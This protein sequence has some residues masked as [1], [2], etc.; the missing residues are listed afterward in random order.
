MPHTD[1]QAEIPWD[2]LKEEIVD[3]Y[4]HKKYTNKQIREVIARRE[5]GLATTKSQLEYQLKKWKICKNMKEAD[6]IFIQTSIN[7]KNSKSSS[8]DHT[9]Y[10]VC[11]SGIRQSPRRI[12]KG[13]RRLKARE[14]AQ[15]VDARELQYYISEG[16]EITNS[17]QISVDKAP[18][19]NARLK[20]DS[21]GL[22]NQA[23]SQTIGMRTA[24]SDDNM[25]DLDVAPGSLW[26][27]RVQEPPPSLEEGS[28]MLLDKMSSL[29]RRREA[30]F[31]FD[32]IRRTLLIMENGFWED[33]EWQPT[34]LQILKSHKIYS[35]LAS[36]MRLGTVESARLGNYLVS[37][38]CYKY[39]DEYD[40]EDLSLLLSCGCAPNLET[41]ETAYRC[42]SSLKLQHLF[43]FW[44]AD[45]RNGLDKQL[46]LALERRWTGILEA[47]IIMNIFT[48]DAM[49]RK[50]LT[51]YSE[52]ALDSVN[53]LTLDPRSPTNFD[54][55]P[56]ATIINH[57]SKFISELALA[58]YNF[59]KIRLALIELLITAINHEH[60]NV[61]RVLYI[62][63]HIDLKDSSY[64][65]WA[66]SAGEVS[67]TEWLLKAGANPNCS[68]SI[69]KARP[70]LPYFESA[71]WEAP[72]SKK[73]YSTT[74][75]L[76]AIRMNS[77][78]IIDLLL[79]FGADPNFKASLPIPG[80]GVNIHI[81]KWWSE[82]GYLNEYFIEISPFE[83]ALIQ[84]VGVGVLKR[85]W[86]A[87]AR[88]QPHRFEK[89]L[90]YSLMYVRVGSSKF[91]F[92]ADA[93]FRSQSWLE[94]IPISSWSLECNPVGPE[95]RY[96]LSLE[97]PKS[98]QKRVFQTFTTNRFR[99][100]IYHTVTCYDNP[101]WG[102]L[103][104]NFVALGD[105]VVVSGA[106][107]F[108][109]EIIS[110]HVEELPGTKNVPSRGQRSEPF[111]RIIDQMM[112][113]EF[114]MIGWHIGLDLQRLCTR[115][116][117]RLAWRG[118]INVANLDQ[119]LKQILGGNMQQLTM[120]FV[121]E[122]LR[123]GSPTSDINIA[124]MFFESRS[125]E[126]YRGRTVL[127]QYVYEIFE[128]FINIG[129]DINERA[130]EC[131]TATALDT[132]LTLYVPDQTTFR[133]IKRLCDAGAVIGS[134]SGG[135]GHYSTLSC[136][137]QARRE[138]SRTS[139]HKKECWAMRTIQ[140]LLRTEGE[141]GRQRSH[142]LPDPEIGGVS[143]SALQEAAYSGD[144]ELVRLILIHFSDGMNSDFMREVMFM[145]MDPMAFDTP[146]LSPLSPCEVLEPFENLPC[147]TFEF[148][149]QGRIVPTSEFG[150]R[151]R[152]SLELA[153][154]RGRQDVVRLLL[155]SG[156]KVTAEVYWKARS[157][158][159]MLQLI[160]TTPAPKIHASECGS[161]IS[162]ESIPASS[163]GAMS[164]ELD[165]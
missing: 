112:E 9:E 159:R 33:F 165:F 101:S 83:L 121:Y 48:D 137:I 99:S 18:Y 122:K 155:E 31:T 32:F 63:Q 53:I 148:R 40:A 64:L 12:K 86:E 111:M 156:A 10:E 117:I 131:G 129:W 145:P 118:A 6:Y 114:S 124:K 134:G 144:L 23:V 97:L 119:R 143:V 92:A 146:E 71:Y 43:R 57:N 38:V 96:T 142:D 69:P 151:F 116:I 153:L 105:D 41:L 60:H 81:S 45:N 158:P 126:G 39:Q 135:R 3:M 52:Y 27:I 30:N 152:P 4:L 16:L 15:D 150:R 34:I 127:N 26:H 109:R 107:K 160:Q 154:D 79:S 82:C 91:R 87:G 65:L 47:V 138:S 88:L 24:D 49:H 84:G 46:D 100:M 19:E 62:S 51:A 120:E 29:T 44:G 14:E 22:S 162:I 141:R 157:M 80:Y 89:I 76:T 125:E 70:S 110:M 21:Q 90:V 56:I 66:I 136:A 74:P 1:P 98:G 93:L 94:G 133:V 11:L 25:D 113:N 36:V 50:I 58:Q 67:T 108:F 35:L 42:K 20:S 59:A 115:S 7:Q 55:E 8:R 130:C 128:Y 75:L 164:M 17:T 2:D 95:P 77:K 85:L 103:M 123:A 132:I 13:L 102:V 37:A 163:V 104:D 68:F 28:N 72:L 161:P 139:F 5:N 78:R 147:P 140:L 61:V 106:F 73:V 54:L 149:G